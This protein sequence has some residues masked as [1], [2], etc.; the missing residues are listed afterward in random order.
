VRFAIAEAMYQNVVALH[1]ANRMLDNNTG[2][3]L[4]SENQNHA[5]A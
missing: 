1:A 3:R 5:T 4:A 2:I